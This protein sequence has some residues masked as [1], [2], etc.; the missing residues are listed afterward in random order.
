MKK[1]LSLSA[2]SLALIGLSGAAQAE[3]DAPGI[4]VGAGYGQYSIQFEDRENDIDFDDDSAVLKGYVGAQFNAYLSLE[5]AYQNFDEANDIDNYA[6]ID[7]LSLAAIVSL[8][9]SENF[10]LFAKGGW[11]EWKADV[12]T[13]IPAIGNITSSQ[14]GGDIFYGAG[15]QYAFTKN[16]RA[17]IEY[18]RFELEDDI[19]P[20]LDV[21]SV[22]IQY[23]F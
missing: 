5:L 20:D 13:T 10:S 15:L 23:M 4:Y 8:P 3:M 14:E 18:E 11:F 1:T 17:R 9:I 19:D 22:S 21:A 2:L 6:E 12:S 16:I 7:G